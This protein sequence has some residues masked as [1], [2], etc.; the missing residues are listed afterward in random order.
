MFGF[1][2]RDLPIYGYIQYGNTAR[3]RVW[4]QIFDLI[5]VRLRRVFCAFRVRNNYHARAENTQQPKQFHIAS[6]C[7]LEKKKYR[8]QVQNLEYCINSR[9]GPMYFLSV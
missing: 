2:G 7:L 8:G 1:K 6:V 5:I 9:L 4:L 3:G